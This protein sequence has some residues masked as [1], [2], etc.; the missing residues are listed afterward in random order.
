MMIMTRPAAFALLLTLLFVLATSAALARGGTGIDPFFSAANCDE[1]C[2]LGIRLGITRL[3]DARAILNAHPSVSSVAFRPRMDFYGNEHLRFTWHPQINS[4]TSWTGELIA[5]YGTVYQVR[6]ETGLSL[7]ELWLALGR[8]EIGASSLVTT[9]GRASALVYASF[10]GDRRIR[11]TMAATCPLTLSSLLQ[12]RAAAIELR[13]TSLPNATDA[14]PSLAA[15][16]RAL[17]R[18]LESRDRAC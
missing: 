15:L 18:P 4:P 14:H 5:S 16:V 12:G 6:L 13:Q 1:P 11:L 2:F 9:R 8:P 17:R 3:S 7:G 10:F